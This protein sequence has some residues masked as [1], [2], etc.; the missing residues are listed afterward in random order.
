MVDSGRGR[1]GQEN[2]HT[3]ADWRWN[4]CINV[5]VPGLLCAS[6]RL[7]PP[8]FTGPLARPDLCHHPPYKHF[9]LHHSQSGKRGRAAARERERERKRES[10]LP[11]PLI[12]P[13]MQ[14]PSAHF[15][16]IALLQSNCLGS[17]YW[18]ERLPFFQ[19]ESCPRRESRACSAPTRGETGAARGHKVAREAVLT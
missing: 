4:K 3:Y 17:A 13:R 2:E 8:L 10:R 12:S 5:C 15:L 7:P 19:A 1:W 9:P 6:P 11:N 16:N 14:I 18:T